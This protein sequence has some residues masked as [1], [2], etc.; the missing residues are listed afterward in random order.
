MNAIKI[1][2][3]RGDVS[4][5]PVVE[6]NDT[7][8][9]TPSGVLVSALGGGP[10]NQPT[11]YGHSYFLDVPEARYSLIRSAAARRAELAHFP[12][13][14]YNIPSAPSWSYS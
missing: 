6:Q 3:D 10:L 4:G 12:I 14:P 5:F 1:A 11:P 8:S 9:C 13:G 2:Y 7:L